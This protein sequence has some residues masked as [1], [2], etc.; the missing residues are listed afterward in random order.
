MAADKALGRFLIAA[1]LAHGLGACD[2]GGAD[3]GPGAVSDGEAAAL[4]EAAKMLD[5]KRL[6]EG[7]L[8]EIDPTAEPQ[9][10]AR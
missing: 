1:L 8:P 9:A 2:G 7:A 10:P 6:P 3:A 4:D 5:E